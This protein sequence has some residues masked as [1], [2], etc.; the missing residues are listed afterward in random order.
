MK[1]NKILTLIPLWKLS[2]LVPIAIGIV[3]IFLAT[4]AQKLQETQKKTIVVHVHN[5][6]YRLEF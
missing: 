2:D 4:N 1:I 6:L 3:A 5:N